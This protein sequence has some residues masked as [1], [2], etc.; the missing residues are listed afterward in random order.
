M[1]NP[2]NIPDAA[3]RA[4]F[5][6][7][8]ALVA[9]ALFR[10]WQS[11]DGAARNPRRLLVALRGAS[12]LL[13][14]CALAGV[15]V[16]YETATEARVLLRQT[17]SV[18][19]DDKAEADASWAT[20]QAAGE[21]VNALKKQSFTVVEEAEA[22]GELMSADDRVYVAGILLTNGAMRQD[23]A[24]SE[25]NRLRAAM[26]GVPVFVVN[27]PAPTKPT[28]A[29]TGVAITSQPV[30]GVP[31]SVRCSVHGRGMRGRE[32]LITIADEAKVQAS[33]RVRWTS[34]EEWRTVTLEVVPKV[35]GWMPYTA[36]I[37]AAGGEDKGVLS[38]PFTLYIEERRWRVLFFEGEPTW[39]AKFI[40][41][42]LERSRL[43]EVDYFAQVSR[44]AAIGATERSSE[45]ADDETGEQD[46]KIDE[47]K[48]RKASSP[49]AKL[50]AV[51]GSMERLNSYD[52]IIVGPTPN[53]ML[54]A[55]EAARLSVWT[56][57]RGGGIIILGGN[58]FA[59][60]IAAPNGKLYALMPAAIDA[61]GLAS[62]AQQLSRGTPLEA[63]KNRDGLS[64][65]PTA[66]GAGSALG[67]YL[68]ASQETAAKTN[69]LTGQGLR[70]GALRPSATVLAVAGR[71]H[72]VE[73]SEAGTPLIVAA[74][75]GAG[76]TLLFA[77]ADSWRLRTSASGEQDEAAAPYGALWH[78]LLLWATAGAKP[79]V[80]IILSDES[81]AAGQLLTAEIRVRDA[82]Y[83]SAKIEKLNARLQPLAN[84]EEE[85]ANNNSQPREIAFVP[86][87]T[88]ASVWRAALP[89]SAPGQYALEADY[90]AGGKSGSSIKYFT[91]VS[92]LAVE[93]GAAND[94]LLRAARE[95]GGDIITSDAAA[96][97]ERINAN[98]LS[99]EKTRLTWELRTWWPLAFIIPL[100]L[101]AAWLIE[102]MNDER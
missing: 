52:C 38:R 66:A 18:V 44:A 94:A 60:S 57:R 37:E 51:L 101:S 69:V 98:S 81:P 61:R 46:E 45:Q 53:E 15:R 28:V 26:G 40:R 89:A 47:G 2:F 90:K 12:L 54:S 97:F 24:A 23:V 11:L 30:S 74:R 92:A 48:A 83:A 75:Y 70:F 34:D 79:P 91:I 4:V 63:E 10:Y 87:E 36:R 102:R 77:P 100:L 32:S 56:E 9:F 14:A 88:D 96:F 95:T 33:A 6:A 20:S 25:V 16:E 93:P 62:E 64:L 65:L 1:S 72:A 5:V 80:E 68:S 82:L 85:T 71:G 99:R 58:S 55:A 27:S 59:G 35:A 19:G 78:G 22:S 31:V 67:A 86:D 21:I 49:E 3:S 13:L 84:D 8:L 41:R 29:I 17:R 7:A 43:F 50:H 42:V 39:E 73:Q 76:R